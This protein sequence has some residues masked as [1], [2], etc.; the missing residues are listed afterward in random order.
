MKNLWII[1]IFNLTSEFC[2]SQITFKKA[3]P[4][5]NSSGYSAIQ[6]LDGGY[7]FV[8]G[9]MMVVKCDSFGDIEWA[10]N[11][12]YNS[13]NI[14]FKALQNPD[15]TYIILSLDP[16]PSLLKLSSTGDTLWAK[17][18]FVS[19]QSWNIYHTYDGGYI[20]SQSLGI[21]KLDVNGN[22]QWAT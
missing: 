16:D 19:Y 9:D 7:L 2:I 14:A 13:L 3:Y 18:Y 17:K 21:I 1:I 15:S 4:A 20:I 5:I 11:Y 6:T 12:K 22:I 8:G 10:N